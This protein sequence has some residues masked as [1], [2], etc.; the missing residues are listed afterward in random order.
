M[1]KK[2]EKEERKKVTR[3]QFLKDLGLFAVA[4]IALNKLDF[5]AGE[6]I[7][8]TSGGSVQPE[9]WQCQ[10][11][12]CIVGG[13]VNCV[14]HFTCETSVTCPTEFYCYSTPYDPTYG[15]TQRI[16]YCEEVFSCGRHNCKAGW[17]S[18]R[19]DDPDEF[20][21]GKYNGNYGG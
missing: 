3:R 4:G 10:G 19:S 11:Y 16:F 2:S 1:E 14:Q 7:K 17:F 20:Y 8:K 5:L 18:C 6:I 13:G 12:Y 9:T 21:C 15:C